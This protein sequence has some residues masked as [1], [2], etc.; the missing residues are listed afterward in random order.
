MQT[1]ILQLD[2]RRLNARVDKPDG[3]LRAS[4]NTVG[5]GYLGENGTLRVGIS[6][7]GIFYYDENDNT[8]AV[9][10][11]LGIFYFDENENVVWATYCAPNC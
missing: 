4:M 2:G 10:D 3:T 9:I 1:P 11:N 7:N 5:I 6:D 8:R